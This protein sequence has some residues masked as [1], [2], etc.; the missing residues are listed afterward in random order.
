LIEYDPHYIILGGK[1]GI[2]TMVKEIQDVYTRRAQEAYDDKAKQ[3]K[4]KKSAKTLIEE[5]TTI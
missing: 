5:S 2:H 3:S 1:N 4:A